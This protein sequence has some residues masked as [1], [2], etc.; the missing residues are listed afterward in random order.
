MTKMIGL[1]KPIFGICRLFFTFQGILNTMTKI[2]EQHIIVSPKIGLVSLG[3]P[4]ALVDSEHILTKLKAEGYE[5][6][7]DY[8]GANAVIVN[9]CGFLDSARDESLEAIG[10]AIA[11]NGTVIVTGCL[12]KEADLIREKFPNVAAITGPHQ[13]EQVLNAVHQYVPQPYNPHTHLLPEQGIKLTPRH[14]AYL[15]ISEGCNNTCSFCIIP[16][17]R[18]KLVSRPIQEVIAEAER[19]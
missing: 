19:L 5:L 7:S 2:A 9:T 14:Y 12:G 4:K 10:E 1:C 15:K 18:G 16:D 8:Q 13:Y 17:L 3:C 6:S 11:E